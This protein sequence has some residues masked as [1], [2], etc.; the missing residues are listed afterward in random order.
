MSFKRAS[1][2]STQSAIPTEQIAFGM[3][4]MLHLHLTHCQMF[5]GMSNLKPTFA[6]NEARHK[7]RCRECKTLKTDSPAM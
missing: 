4:Y 1:H 2:L 3:K 6:K 5:K 7:L